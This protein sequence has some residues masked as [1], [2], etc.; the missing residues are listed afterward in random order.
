LEQVDQN[1]L[2]HE[3]RKTGMLVAPQLTVYVHYE[4]II[5]GKFIPDILVERGVLV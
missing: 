1:S 2:V 3:L 4:D 5:F